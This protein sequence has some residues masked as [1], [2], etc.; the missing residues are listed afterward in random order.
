MTF[1][2]TNTYILGRGEVAVMDPGP[3]DPTH[4]QAILDATRGETIT[5]IL[6]SHDHHD[7]SALVPKLKEATGAPLLAFH[8]PTS[9]L[10]PDVALQDGDRVEGDTWAVEVIHTPGHTDDHL[11]FATGDLCLT[12]DHVMGWATS[13]I[14]PPRGNLRAYMDSL[15]KM[16][17]RPWRRFLS[18][19]GD[20][21]EEPARRL[22]A[23]KAS[24]QAREASILSLLDSGGLTLDDLVAQLYRRL[25]PGLARAARLNVE[26]HVIALAE[27]GRLL[28]EGD[29]VVRS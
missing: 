21:I 23:L 6:M 19:H 8:A 16:A 27:D 7:H 20:P 17:A 11:C 4:L 10:V 25:G 3:D 28:R 9:A 1:R 18:A 14:I 29:R 13:A 15:D 12:G 5:H 22:E 24:R 26:A 2:G